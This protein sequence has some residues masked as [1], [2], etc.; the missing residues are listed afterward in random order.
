MSFQILSILEDNS[1]ETNTYVKRLYGLKVESVFEKTLT[2]NPEIIAQIQKNAFMS[3]NSWWLWVG[4]KRTRIKDY[5][6]QNRDAFRTECILLYSDLEFGTLLSPAVPLAK[7]MDGIE[8][9]NTIFR[10]QTLTDDYVFDEKER[11]IHYKDVP[12]IDVD[13]IYST[14]LREK[15]IELVLNELEKHK[16]RCRYP[17]KVYK[18]YAPNPS[19][20]NLDLLFRVPWEGVIWIKLNFAYFYHLIQQRAGGIL[21]GKDSAYWGQLAERYKAGEEPLLTCEVTYITY[22]DFDP[23]K[24]LSTALSFPLIPWFNNYQQYILNPLTLIERNFEHLIYVDKATALIPDSVGYKTKFPE[25]PENPNLVFYAV[26]PYQGRDKGEIVLFSLTEEGKFH[27]IIIAPTRSGKSFTAQQIIAEALGID[28][29]VLFD[30]SIKPFALP[31]KVAYF[32]VGFSAEF[33]TTLMKERGFNVEIANPDLNVK[34]NPFDVDDEKEIDVV[35]SLV[36]LVLSSLRTDPLNAYQRAFLEKALK[37][38]LENKEK[39]LISYRSK[40]AYIK[41][42]SPSLYQKLRERYDDNVP[43]SEIIQ[44]DSDFKMLDYPIADD[45]IRVLKEIRTEVG[46][47][48]EDGREIGEL[49]RKLEAIKGKANFNSWTEFLIRDR[50]FFYY[51]LHF[52]KK[53]DI[54]VPLYMAVLYKTL[55]ALEHHFSMPK[56]FIAD[57]FHNLVKN[58]QFKEFFEVLVREAAKRNISLGFIS[59]NADDIPDEIALNIGTK[60][61][62]K[63]LSVSVGGGEEKEERQR[64]YSAFEESIKRKFKIPAVA[65]ERFRLLP[66]YTAFVVYGDGGFFSMQFPLT[67]AKRKVFESRTIPVLETPDGIRIKKTFVEEK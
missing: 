31:V 45:V 50:D 35:V 28:V 61:F 7:Q 21:A 2:A 47:D 40:V 23:P 32:D 18:G 48:S 44:R 43:I 12:S 5:P 6:D 38:I 54:F 20:P 10:F 60:I 37:R 57:E 51:D 24:E 11:K 56:L 3:Q 17:F 25:D 63:P 27:F 29:D 4:I 42:F 36:S 65:I 34:V 39:Y 59:Q 9:A 16:R 46:V 62:L 1:V 67:E 52:I 53:S 19:N 58:P 22:A 14:L 41:R 66:Q 64:E 8:L 13:T 26:A 55:K 33:F 15:Y 49:I 30:G